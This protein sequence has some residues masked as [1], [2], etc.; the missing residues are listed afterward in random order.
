[1]YKAI[2]GLASLA[3]VSILLAGCA[4]MNPGGLNGTLDGDP[5]TRVTY[6]C[7]DGQCS[8]DQ[9]VVVAIAAAMV[10]EQLIPQFSGQLESA[11]TGC[12]VYGT[13]YGAGGASQS[14]F[15]TGADA[16]AAAGVGG[17]TGCLGGAAN[18]LY[19]YSYA[20]DTSTGTHTQSV[21][22]DWSKGIKI[23]PIIAKLYPNVGELSQ[24]VSV[25]AS[26]IRT[27]N[28]TSDAAQNAA[29][30]IWHGPAV[31]QPIAGGVVR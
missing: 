28:K 26:Y 11:A 29:Q 31:G 13:A 24:G 8:A 15:Y 25:S 30:Q 19:T 17:V 22:N 10:N 5:M 21:L 2:K 7:S 16:G 9:I 12:V 27:T 1:M 4:G 18:G 6:V 14:L 23:P 3:L 20:I